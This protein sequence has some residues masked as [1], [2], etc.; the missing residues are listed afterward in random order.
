MTKLY[1]EM[2]RSDHHKF[3]RLTR[4]EQKTLYLYERLHREYKQNYNLATNLLSY[5]LLILY[6]QI[7]L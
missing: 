6:A 4:Y 7:T 1:L 5:F 2:L 3:Y